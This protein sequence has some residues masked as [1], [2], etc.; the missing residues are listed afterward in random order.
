MLSSCMVGKNSGG[1]SS[2]RSREGLNFAM[3]QTLSR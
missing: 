2:L 3:D 1:C